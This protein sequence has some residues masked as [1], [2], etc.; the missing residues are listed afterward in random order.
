[1]NK[2]RLGINKIIEFENERDLS[3]EDKFIFFSI[4]FTLFFNIK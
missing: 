1:M 2:K 4:K 3:L